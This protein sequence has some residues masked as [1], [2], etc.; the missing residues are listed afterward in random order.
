MA[1]RLSAEARSR[2]MRAI[3]H[4]NTKPE[5]T[6]RKY[7][8]AEGY[9]YRLHRKGLPG[10]PDLV[11]PGR[12]K[13]IFVHGCF[14]HQH[15]AADCPIRVVPSSNQGYWTPKLS[16]NITRD[17]ENEASLRKLGWD[18]LVVWECELRNDAEAV[19][20]KM[21]K[22]LGPAARRKSERD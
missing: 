15:S 17:A 7:L 3:R 13:V 19:R 10:K 5:Q 22:F 20:K 11:F 12:K 9:R 2:I 6:V 8:F 14:W 1:D 21:N 16:R 4:K 18:V